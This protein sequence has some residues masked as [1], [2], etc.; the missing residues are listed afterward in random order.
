VPS[1]THRPGNN[2]PIM[3]FAAQQNFQ[4]GDPAQALS[5]TRVPEQR[6]PVA[7]SA[8]AKPGADKSA[9]SNTAPTGAPP[10]AAG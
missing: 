7:R 5:G 3:P 4:Y 1:Y 2:L 8:R 9:M 10:Q 6:G